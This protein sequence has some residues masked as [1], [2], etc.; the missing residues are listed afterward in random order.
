MQAHDN[1]STDTENVIPVPRASLIS[2]VNESRDVSEQQIDAIKM[3]TY[4]MSTSPLTKPWDPNVVPLMY[5]ELIPYGLGGPGVTY[6][7]KQISAEN[8]YRHSLKLSLGKF[9]KHPEYVMERADTFSKSE[10]IRSTYISLQYSNDDKAID[11]I[12]S[13]QVRTPSIH[14]CGYAMFCLIRLHL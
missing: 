6:R 13:D 12:T 3:Y 8:W 1:L 4:Q 14:V 9:A 5:P 2:T 11:E 7:V 10:G